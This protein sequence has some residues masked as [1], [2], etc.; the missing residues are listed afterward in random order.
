[1]HCFVRVISVISTLILSFATPVLFFAPA[2]YLFALHSVPARSSQLRAPAPSPAP[3]CP[4]LSARMSRTKNSCV[5]FEDDPAQFLVLIV[6]VN[7]SAWA[8]PSLLLPARSPDAAPLPIGP[9]A[10]AAA[11]GAAPAAPN[12]AVA[13]R[14]VLEDVLDQLSAFVN[15]FALVNPRNELAIIATDQFKNALIYPAPPTLPSSS[16]VD[17][18]A[19]SSDFS[20]SDKSAA[21]GTATR[22]SGDD[23]ENVPLSLWS[24]SAGVS[25]GSAAAALRTGLRTRAAVSARKLAR[26]AA[27][28]PAAAE[29]AAASGSCV[30]GALSQAL[31]LIARAK[32]RL[33]G[34]ADAAAAPAATAGGGGA[35]MAGDGGGAYGRQAVS[36]RVVVVQ[37]SADRQRDY[38]GVMNA[39]FV[40][41]RQGVLVDAVALG[42][43]SSL[44]LHQAAYVTKSLYASLALA[45]PVLPTPS[46]PTA[47]NSS[48]ASAGSGGLTLTLASSSSTNSSTNST[49][50]STGSVSSASP[51]AAPASAPASAAAATAPK[52]SRAGTSVATAAAAAGTSPLALL[53]H[54]LTALLA[55]APLRPLLQIP[56][57]ATADLRATCFCHAKPVKTAHVCPVCLA[58]YCDPRPTC[59]ACGTRF[60][61]YEYCDSSTTMHCL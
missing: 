47:T 10:A 35:A 14:P 8:D 7:P 30:A 11:P 26:L 38:V 3:R 55:P 42:G 22:T 28:D 1:M 37:A 6:D 54:L 4:R 59:P 44:L 53:Q 61:R 50:N 29:Q 56:Q 49:D 23:D 19:L 16:S 60:A 27:Q 17:G 2:S 12:S 13:V 15:A 52:K 43:V 40:A 31:C 46:N 18:P 5:T 34:A 25:L 58:V 33:S 39:L 51:A 36:A 32:H 21:T 41:Q 9:H 24:H 57:T 20:S 48:G 45:A